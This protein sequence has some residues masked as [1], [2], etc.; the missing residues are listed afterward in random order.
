MNHYDRKDTLRLRLSHGLLLPLV[1]SVKLI[2]NRWRCFRIRIGWVYAGP[3]LKN[4]RFIQVGIINLRRL[5]GV[6]HD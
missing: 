5:A 4:Q 3:G 1:W 2:R 6:R